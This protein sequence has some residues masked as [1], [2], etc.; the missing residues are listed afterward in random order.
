MELIIGAVRME[1]P[2]GFGM[3]NRGEFL[4]AGT[5]CRSS[6]RAAMGQMGEPG[7]EGIWT[8]WCD[9]A[10]CIALAHFNTTWAPGW[11]KMMSLLMRCLVTSNEE[12]EDGA[13]L[14]SLKK[15]KKC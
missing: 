10:L 5:K 13:T 6:L 8:I 9:W 3:R 4:E 12:G 14:D 11:P 7:R 1:R 2:E 15:V